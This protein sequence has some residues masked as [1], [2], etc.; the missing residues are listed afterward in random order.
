MENKL[1][2]WLR[3]SKSKTLPQNDQP[4]DVSPKFEVSLVE[5]EFEP[6]ESAE[7]LLSLL[8]YKVKFHSV[9]LLNLKEV[10]NA[11]SENSQKRIDALKAAKQE[12][13][14]LVLEA[15]NNGWNLQIDSTI[16]ITPKMPSPQNT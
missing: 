2:Q 5:G 9:R 16:K 10:K 7:V 12:V 15:R 1:F 6:A 13:T 8:N 11:D 3:G 14:K 4:S